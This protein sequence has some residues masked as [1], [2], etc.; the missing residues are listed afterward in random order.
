MPALHSQAGRSLGEHPS[1]VLPTLALASSFYPSLHPPP[2]HPPDSTSLCCL[3]NSTW[4]LCCFPVLQ[5]ALPSF[6]PTRA[7]LR[8]WLL[9]TPQSCDTHKA[10]WPT[11]RSPLH[12]THS[13]SLSLLR[14]GMVFRHPSPCALRCLCRPRPVTDLGALSWASRISRNDRKGNGV[15]RGGVRRLSKV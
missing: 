13:L 10:L 5:R 14:V 2:F 8:P 9:Q 15:V 4:S 6:S 7:L 11:P 3:I 12:G 1:H